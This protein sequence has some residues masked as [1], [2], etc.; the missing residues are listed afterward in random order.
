MG[1]RV[2]IMLSHSILNEA[3]RLFLQGQRGVEVVDP[4]GAA[5]TDL[6]ALQPDVIL[7]EE[8]DS[9]DVRRYLA[10]V[11]TARVISFGRDGALTIYQK[12][13]MRVAR[14]DDL[15]HV[16]EQGEAAQSAA[17]EAFIRQRRGDR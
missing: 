14:L 16:V 9:I 8:D 1:R 11:P 5:G 15:L 4:Q 12:S 13:E 2:L 3:V 6:A 7:S 10:N 17:P